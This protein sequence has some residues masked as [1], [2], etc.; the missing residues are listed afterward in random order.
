MWERI[1]AIGTVILII[2]ALVSISQ[3][4]AIAW[5]HW[6]GFMLPLIVV[7]G[8]VVAAVLNFRTAT[9]HTK[10]P[11]AANAENG[12]SS[13]CDEMVVD[14]AKRTTERIV[15]VDTQPQLHLQEADPYLDFSITFINATVFRIEAL[16][17]EGESYFG[18]TPLAQHPRLLMSPDGRLTLYHGEKRILNIRQ[19]L[20]KDVAATLASARGIV[21]LDFSRVSLQ[22][23]V[24]S[25]VPGAPE[26]FSWR[27]F[28][29]LQI[30]Y[31]D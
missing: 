7:C 20:S 5:L 19:F 10:L 29:N 28:R 30:A 27:N 3:G 2:L 15:I 8:L 4:P 17:I 6:P 23:K 1:T 14:D 11:L 16:K 26:T 18:R 25:T 9:L 22:F 24:L 12:P 21:Q 13:W 31:R